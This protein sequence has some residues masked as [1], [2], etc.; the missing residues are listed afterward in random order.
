MIDSK[1]R[2]GTSDGAQVLGPETAQPA[3]S[4]VTLQIAKDSFGPQLYRQASKNL[5][6][7]I[8]IILFVF[9]VLV[10]LVQYISNRS[11]W[12]DEALLSLNFLHHTASELLLRP[13]ENHQGAPLAFLL[14]QRLAVLT[15]GPNEYSLRLFP[16]VAGLLSIFVFH[17]VARN[18]LGQKSAL[19]ALYFFVISSSLIYYSS[20]AKQYSTDVLVALLLY[21]AVS[22]LQPRVSFADAVLL[23]LAGAAGV[24]LSHPAIFVFAGIC[25]TLLV[26]SLL[27]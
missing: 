18:W 21:A 20:M 11:L 24:W 2:P 22:V 25:A 15:L 14:V 23:G 7:M 16:L 3:A 19:V 1:S 17:A 5:E 26:S 10:R 12:L 13:L 4:E 9:G 6:R 27:A 8:L